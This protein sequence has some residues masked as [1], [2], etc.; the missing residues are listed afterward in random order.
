MKVKK[1]IE[2]YYCSRKSRDEF[3]RKARVDN[4]PHEPS[5]TKSLDIDFD[6]QRDLRGFFDGGFPG[7]YYHFVY[8][9]CCQECKL[10][11]SFSEYVEAE[12]YDSNNRKKR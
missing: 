7:G 6:E 8:K 2:Q 3:R 9:T 1:R 5:C 4:H 10:E 11:S 12:K